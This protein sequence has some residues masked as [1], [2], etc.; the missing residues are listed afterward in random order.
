[1]TAFDASQ[2]AEVRK[3]IIKRRRL[4]SRDYRRRDCPAKRTAPSMPFRL[5][6]DLSIQARHLLLGCGI[7]SLHPIYINACAV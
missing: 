5:A 3:P 2:G 4:Q 1:M 7:S 6:G